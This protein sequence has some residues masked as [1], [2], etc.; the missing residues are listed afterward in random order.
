MSSLRRII[1]AALVLLTGCGFGFISDAELGDRLDADGDGWPRRVDCDDNDR[2]VTL[3]FWFV[4]AD[5]DGFGDGAEERVIS[6]DWRPGL[7]HQAGDCDDSRPL[8]HPGA[9]EFCNQLDDDCD[10]RADNNVSD[11]PLFYR[12]QDGDT[13]GDEDEWVQTCFAPEGWVTN[14]LDCDDKDPD[15]HSGRAFYRDADG[16]DWG[17][18]TSVEI[19]CHA[20]GNR[21][22]R[23]GDCDDNNS[24]VNPGTV[25]VCDDEG[26]DEDCD[27]MVNDA[28]P[29]V[30]T[31]LGV[32]TWLDGDGD[33][34]GDATE[35]MVRCEADPEAGWVGNPDDCDDSDPTILDEDCPYLAV[36]A[37]ESASCAIRGDHRVVCWGDD[38]IALNRPTGRYLDVS[39]GAGHACALSLD[40]SLECW[41]NVGTNTFESDDLLAAVNIDEDYTCALTDNEDIQCWANGLE[42]RVGAADQGFTA[43]AVGTSHACGLMDNEEVRCFGVCNRGECLL[44]TG[45]WKDVAA[46]DEFSCVLDL[47]GEVMCRGDYDGAEPSTD[48]VQ[49]GAYGRQV[50]AADAARLLTCWSAT[51]GEAVAEPPD[52]TPLMA[53]DVGEDH[54][55]GITASDASLV[56]W[57]DDSSGKATP[58]LR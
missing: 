13:F 48:F 19:D 52:D 32:N 44:P 34:L 53:W 25:E 42:Y 40:R 37:G 27:G 38:L 58:P 43:L 30:D 20:M 24:A 15:T 5:R 51:G 46:G 57:G 6:C 22:P 55:C 29:S 18:P 47:S 10:G 26:L 41:G 23:G 14:K 21:V 7:A 28:D 17:D 11:L 3:K 12:D 4:D 2:N 54:G 36:S 39:V 8:A 9:E 45:S 1:A 56:C 35:W 31:A 16:D 50:C 49:I 33:G